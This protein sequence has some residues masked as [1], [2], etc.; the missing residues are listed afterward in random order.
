MS[1]WHLL[2]VMVEHLFNFLFYTVPVFFLPFFEGGRVSLMK[3]MV[4]HDVP[5]CAHTN[6]KFKNSAQIHHGSCIPL[7]SYPHCSVAVSCYHVSM[8]TAYGMLGPAWQGFGE[9]RLSYWDR[10][11]DKHDRN[12]RTKSD[13]DNESRN[14]YTKSKNRRNKGKKT[15]KGTKEQRYQQAFFKSP[16]CNT[17]SPVA[18][19]VHTVQTM[20]KHGSQNNEEVEVLW[21]TGATLSVTPFLQDFCTDVEPTKEAMVMKGIAKGLM[22]K[23][24]GQVS[25]SVEDDK[26]NI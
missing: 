19:T 4:N 21:D 6:I 7:L 12:F 18:A 3:N 15:T 10:Q 22:V 14:C 25:Y 9:N 8:Q 24:I 2:S 26:G 20:F 16:S 11:I 13:S 17:F 5:H 23:G 1:W